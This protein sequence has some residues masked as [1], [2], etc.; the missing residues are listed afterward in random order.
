PDRQAE[1]RGEQALEADHA[2]RGAQRRGDREVLGDQLAEDHRDPGGED[3][4][5]GHGDRAGGDR[6]E[7]GVDEAG[8]DELGDRGLREEADAQV[9][10]GDPQLRPGELCGER[11]HPLQDPAGALVAGLGGRFHVVAVDGDQGE[12]GGDEATA[13][14]D[15]QEADRQGDEG[16]DQVHGRIPPWQV[17]ECRPEGLGLSLGA[18]LAALMI[19]W[20]SS[21]SRRPSTGMQ[22][23]YNSVPGCGEDPARRRRKAAS[24]RSSTSSTAWPSSGRRSSSSCVWVL[25]NSRVISSISPPNS[26]SRPPW[27]HSTG[28][29]AAA[30]AA[31]PGSGAGN[32]TPERITTKSSARASRRSRWR[33][34]SPPWE[35]PIAPTTGSLCAAIQV[36]T[37][38]AAGSIA[39]GRCGSIGISNQA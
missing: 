2:L 11:L 37:A 6:A 38:A 17:S 25:R 4:G 20:C 3:Q 39:S 15:E 18:S 34:S 10:D 29:R 23:C 26:G 30:S 9:G 7:P 5:D 28:G 22:E 1:E 32:G 14:G 31:S 21:S 16:T 35:K 13:G 19:S 33:A 24:A 27:P 8:A 12:L 36:S